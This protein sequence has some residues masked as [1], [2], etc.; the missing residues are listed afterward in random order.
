MRIMIG[1][2]LVGSLG[3]ILALLG[4]FE[5]EYLLMILAVL[6]L[7]GHKKYL[8]LIKYAR[9]KF[10][11]SLEVIRSDLL[12]TIVLGFSLLV[13]GSLYLSAMS[14]PQATDELHYH[15]PQAR[16]VAETGR[17]GWSWDEHYFFGNI[18]KLM[19]V[20]FAEG[21]L[22]SDY[23][24]AHSLNYLMLV[25]FLILVF[26]LIKDKF[27]YKAAVFAVT[28]LLLFEDLTWNATVGFVDTATSSLE[29]GSLLLVTEWVSKRKDN[30]LMMAGLLLGLGLGMKYS[31]LPTAL[32]LTIIILIIN[33]RKILVFGIPAFLVGGYWYVK[34]WI[35][36]GNPFY[37]MYFG[38]N[39][40]N[41]DVYFRLMNNIWQ[42]EPK[43]LH[44]FLDKLKR[45][46]SYSGSTTYVS[47]WLAPFA[48]LVNIKDK[49][50]LI[51]T[52]YY[53]L[54]IP[55]WFFLATHQT[56]FLLT[57]LVVASIITGILFS[58]IPSKLL[59]MGLIFLVLITL[60][61]R[62]YPERNLFEHYLWIKLHTVERQYALGNISEREFLKR[63]FGCQY[64]VVDY[65]NTN[66]LLGRVIDN[67]S[68]WHAPSVNYFSNY[69]QFT[70]YDYTN[71]LK[72][73]DYQYYYLNNEVKQK[74]VS[75]LNPDL[76]SRTK[77]LLISDEEIIPSLELIFESGECKLFKIK[78]D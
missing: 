2:G 50:L 1:L 40:V 8:E 63:K 24:L 9:S 46:W 68:A 6:I 55:Y 3:L 23:S 57:G 21:L 69:N 44:T 20:I 27:G 32:Y 54:Y 4:V 33:F 28:L 16:S 76:L 61:F 35:L 64:E 48:G 19:E 58:K 34:N 18:P 11:S 62:P 56:R 66:N 7:I 52:G 12:A 22:V 15:F 72:F 53:V 13:A 30:L 14:P 51:L 47:I 37:P 65:L 39:G 74:H 60:R 77:N 49:F 42:W 17:V 78:N 70:S 71:R 59:W 36:F 67:W 26:G 25:G 10:I 29:I 5:K 43:T 31:P 41:D 45:W 38:H 75:D 73:S